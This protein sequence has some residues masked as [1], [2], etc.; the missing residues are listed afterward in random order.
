[1]LFEQLAKVQLLHVPYKGGGPAIND[2]MG[3]QVPLFFANVASSLSHI[4]SGRLRPLA[5]TAAVRC[6]PCP[7]YRPWLRPA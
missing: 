3:G 5:V 2:V 7:T 1:M 4:Q 6:R